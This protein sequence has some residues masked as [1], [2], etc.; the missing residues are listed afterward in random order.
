ML[1][2]LITR[3][4]A[5]SLFWG[6]YFKTTVHGCSGLVANF[7]DFKKGIIAA[8]E[9]GTPEIL[10]RIWAENSYRQDKY[11]S[12][13][14][15]TVRGNVPCIILPPTLRSTKWSLPFRFSNRNF[16]FL[17][18]SSARTARSNQN[19]AVFRNGVLHYEK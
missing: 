4:N 10:W 8:V 12:C 13:D 18:R 7:D 11:L 19:K 5:S 1:D 3:S 6:G 14:E 17:P 2:L 16:K 9:T 15:S